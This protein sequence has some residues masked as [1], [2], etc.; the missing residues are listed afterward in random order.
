[1]RYFT[2]MAVLILAAFQTQQV[3]ARDD[4]KIAVEA[5]VPAYEQALQEY[6]F[7]KANSLL[8]PD[9]KWIEDSYPEPAA[10]R[11]DNFG[12]WWQQAKAA[13]LRVTNHPRDF[14][15]H[16]QGGVAWVIVLVDVGHVADN[17]AARA[18]TRRDHPNEREWVTHFVESEVLVKTASGW[19]IALAHTSS[20]PTKKP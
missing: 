16:I 4:E 12:D 20:L 5:T 7:D 8:M 9:A 3:A 13:R 18:F 6:D 15:T 1:M 19:K 11:A 14:S 17:D 10:I 2:L